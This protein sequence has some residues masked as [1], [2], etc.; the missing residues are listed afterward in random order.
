MILELPVEYD[1]SRPPAELLIPRS[2]HHLGVVRLFLPYKYRDPDLGTTR[3]VRWSE[4][5]LAKSGTMEIAPDTEFFSYVFPPLD[6]YMGTFLHKDDDPGLVDAQTLAALNDASR[7]FGRLRGFH[8]SE[9]DATPRIERRIDIYGSE[10]DQFDFIGG[11]IN[12]SLRLPQFVVDENAQF[13]WGANLYPDSILIAAPGHICDQ[14]LSDPRIDCA[15]VAHGLPRNSEI[16]AHHVSSIARTPQHRTIATLEMSAEDLCVLLEKCVFPGG[17]KHPR[18]GTHQKGVRLQASGGAVLA[19]SALVDDHV[20]AIA[21]PLY[22]DPEL[23]IYINYRELKRL[24]TNITNNRYNKFATLTQ[25]KPTELGLAPQSM[26]TA[27]MTLSELVPTS[28]NH[29]DESFPVLLSANENPDMSR[30][31]LAVDSPSESIPFKMPSY[32]VSWIANRVPHIAK[33][34]SD[35]IQIGACSGA[36]KRTVITIAKNW[37]ISCVTRNDE[38]G[39]S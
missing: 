25:R 19:S 30:S 16:V 3:I 1:S 4:L 8:W 32:Y 29:A 36:D 13:A 2:H 15:L 7:P 5:E 11:R 12:P 27:T 21:T 39:N 14:L 6:E 20:Q 37:R 24:L 18:F 26:G 38:K 31:F 34:S 28:P 35:M 17:E 23:D 22:V 9:L 33:D 10:Y